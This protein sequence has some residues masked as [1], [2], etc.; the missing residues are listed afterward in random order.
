M[1]CRCTVG[2][3]DDDQRVRVV[4]HRVVAMALAALI[5]Y[6]AA[7][8]MPMMGIERFGYDSEVS[9]WTGMVGLF[10]D[11]HWFIGGVIFLF[12]IVAPI[13]K[14]GLLLV[15]CLG[16]SVMG[17]LERGLAFRAVERLGRW[18]MVDVMLVAI[19][20]AVVK[21]GDVVTVTPG[22]GMMV[23]GVVVLMSIV[24]SGMF[25][26]RMIWMTDGSGRGK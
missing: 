17:D 14:L 10:A 13:G 6:P 1:R 4:C 15:V 19:L 12:S 8:M 24:A 9:I 25:E 18:G 22:A 2:H 23:F 11:G 3:G 21:L 20:V 5:L 7:I 16:R 26:P